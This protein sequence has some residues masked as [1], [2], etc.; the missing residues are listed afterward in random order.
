MSSKG[1]AGKR[2]APENI[3]TL[4]SRLSALLPGSMPSLIVSLSGGPNGPFEM[5]L[6]RR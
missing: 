3:S 1:P 5:P 4:I 6:R 2:L